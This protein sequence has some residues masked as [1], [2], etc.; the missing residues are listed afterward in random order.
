MTPKDDSVD[1]TRLRAQIVEAGSLLSV[2]HMQLCD[3]LDLV[4]TSGAENIK[5]SVPRSAHYRGDA[6]DVRNWYLK[7]LDPDLDGWA[8]KI[9]EQIGPDYVVLNEGTHF[10]IHWSPIYHGS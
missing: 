6:I 10:H 2:W 7:A 3:G 8:M 1:L 5:H 4:V 9:R